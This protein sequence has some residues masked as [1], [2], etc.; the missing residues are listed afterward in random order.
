[1][2]KQD[3]ILVDR[4]ITKLKKGNHTNFLDPRELKLVIPFLSKARLEYQI[5]QPYNECERVILYIVN[6]PIL[7]LIEIKSNDIL[8]HRSIM[9]VLYNYGFDNSIFSDII[10]T[11]NSAYFYTFDM[12]IYE[13][14]HT[15]N[16]IGKIK[17]ELI[18][19]DK[20][21]IKK[22]KKNYETITIK[23]P[24]LRIDAV[25]SKLLRLSRSKVTTLIE[26]KEVTYN[27]S[28]LKNFSLILKQ[29]DTFSI[30]RHGKY[31]YIGI[32]RTDKKNNIYIDLLKY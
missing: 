14:T 11:N 18:K 26:L 24:S 27:Y 10:I 19:V 13:L 17:V 22:Y 4:V 15:I 23:V 9:G 7:D 16:K 1:M 28:E 2:V 30:R 29:E 20:N 25:I 31:K 21:I 6:K 5:Y 32:N 8:E 3:K 12:Y